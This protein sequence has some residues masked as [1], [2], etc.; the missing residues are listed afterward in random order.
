[1]RVEEIRR[2]ERGGK[3]GGCRTGAKPR[4]GKRLHTLAERSSNLVLH[5]N[6][7]QYRAFALGKGRGRG[8]LKKEGTASK[9][10][11]PGRG[12]RWWH[13][14]SAEKSG[15]QNRGENYGKVKMSRP[16]AGRGVVEGG[17][18]ERL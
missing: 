18:G 1:L 13:L 9:D 14:V 3:R 2:A 15:F 8:S 10:G 12:I 11:R 16:C 7:R 4:G 17:K 6:A 5:N